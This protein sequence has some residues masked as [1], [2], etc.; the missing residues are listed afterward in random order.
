[1]RMLFR[2]SDVSVRL[3]EQSDIAGLTTLLSDCISN[4]N[5][6]GLDQWDEIY[7]GEKKIW[8]DIL[9]KQL[10]VFFGDDQLVASLVLNDYQDPEYSEIAWRYPS[11]KVAVV[12]RLMVSPTHE[13][14][15]F[16]STAMR[17]AEDEAVRQ[18]YTTIRLDAFSVNQRAL[19]LYQRLGYEDV[20][21][22]KFRKGWFRCFEKYLLA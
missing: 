19:R 20:G 2:R 3:A 10:Y 18:G 14:N 16:A 8:S 4:M 21:A 9:G 15:G 13:G 5:A 11:A 17:F 22:V 7:P 1:M 6:I 12:H